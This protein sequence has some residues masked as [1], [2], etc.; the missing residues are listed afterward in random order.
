MSSEPRSGLKTLEELR[1][2]VLEGR[3]SLTIQIRDTVLVHDERC[4]VWKCRG[5]PCNCA[6]SVFP[7]LS[8]LPED[9]R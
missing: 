1:A 8:G 4:A 5:H 7:K 2:E 3:V 9:L 6:V